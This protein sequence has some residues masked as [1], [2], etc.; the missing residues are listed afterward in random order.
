MDATTTTDEGTRVFHDEREPC[1]VLRPSQSER[2]V[3]Q[4]SRRFAQAG[5]LRQRLLV[6][7]DTGHAAIVPVGQESGVAGLVAW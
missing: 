7:V 3:S 2:L 5:S 1:S 4:S 6:V